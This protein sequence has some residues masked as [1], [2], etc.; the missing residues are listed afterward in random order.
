[1]YGAHELLRAITVVLG[2]AAVTTV[3]FQRLRQPVVLGY[4][5]AGLIV[6]PHI[7][8]PLIADRAIIQTLSELGVILLMFA[9]GLEFSLRKLVQVGPTA[10]LTAIVQTSIMVWLG[11]IVG[12]AFGWTARESIF[13]GAIIAISSTTIIAKAFDEHGIR[14][15][16]RELVVG[17]LIV[18]DL[19]AILLMA[20]L[21]AVSTGSGLSAGGLAFTVGK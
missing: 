7:P 8:I 21:T 9:L 15:K 3:V 4:L 18:E 13:A 16:L 2:V 1:M 11:F 14:G 6:G 12:R 5:L 10:G 19:V 17:V 20:M